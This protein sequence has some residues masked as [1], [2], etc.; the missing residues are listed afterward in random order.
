MSVTTYGLS[1]GE[2]EPQPNFRASRDKNGLYTATQSY[3]MLRS[4]WEQG[5]KGT[6]RRDTPV[7]NLFTDLELM[8][9]FLKLKEFEIER[10]PG[11]QVEV[12][13]TFSGLDPDD[14]DDRE[15]TWILNGVLVERPITEH[16]LFLKEVPGTMNRTYIQGG[17]QGIYIRDPDITANVTTQVDGVYLP[18]DRRMPVLISGGNA[19]KWWR[20][21]VDDGH[22]TWKAPTLQWTLEAANVGGLVDADL[23]LLGMQDFPPGPP[24]K[25]A[26]PQPFKGNHEWLMVAANN[27]IS[28]GGTSYSIT[29]ELSTAAGLPKFRQNGSED[30]EPFDG[31]YSYDRTILEE[32]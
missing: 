5:V 10:A 25:L 32:A 15:I 13:C 22:H 3:R 18:K 16:P 20:L 29:W 19:L 11:G 2:F 23:E 14:E 4:T 1:A 17:M 24:P 26:P 8:W 28:T 6:F 31:P 12:F 27:V 21:I 9:R 7:T 30:L